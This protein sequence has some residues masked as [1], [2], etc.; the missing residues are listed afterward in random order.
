MSIEE[1]IQKL[2]D[3]EAELGAIDVLKELTEDQKSDII[4]ILYLFPLLL[5][6]LSL[7][8]H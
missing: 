4:K 7:L 5:F 8:Y 3:I 2:K 1:K 6:Q